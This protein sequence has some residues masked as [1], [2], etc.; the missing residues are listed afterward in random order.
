M[1]TSLIISDPCSIPMFDYQRV[2]SNHQIL[3]VFKHPRSDSVAVHRAQ[4]LDAFVDD[5]VLA[6]VG[7]DPVPFPLEHTVT[8]W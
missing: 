4:V 6:S 8:Q 2:Q 1:G 5:H 7:N 3:E